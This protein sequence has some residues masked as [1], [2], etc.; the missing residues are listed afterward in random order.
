MSTGAPGGG[1]AAP[2]DAGQVVLRV[3]VD[4]AGPWRAVRGPAAA[5]LPPVL[6]R[7][8]RAAEACLAALPADPSAQAAAVP[9]L[10]ATLDLVERL[11]PAGLRAAHAAPTPAAA[12]RVALLRALPLDPALDWADPAA[13]TAALA[14]AATIEREGGLW[15]IDRVARHLGVTPATVRARTRRGRLVALPIA[16]RG[17]R[18][19]AWQFAN[20]GVLPDLAESLAMLHGAGLQPWAQCRF[21]LT[22]RDDLAGRDPRTVLLTGERVAVVQAARQERARAR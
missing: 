1:A 16:A 9:L 13:V 14:L 5:T 4:P 2:P 22:A 15:D 18:Y 20:R 7:A 17:R 10:A 8:L 3:L 19:P 6:R 21:F 11:D 12:L